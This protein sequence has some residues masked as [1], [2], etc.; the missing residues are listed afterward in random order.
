MVNE[1]SVGFLLWRNTSIPWSHS[2]NHV[3]RGLNFSINSWQNAN[4]CKEKDE[5]VD[6]YFKVACHFY[7]LK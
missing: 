2:M 4:T 6:I 5:D 1:N 7:S 3:E